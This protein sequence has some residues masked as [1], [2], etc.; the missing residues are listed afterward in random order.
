MSLVNC[1]E[2]GNQVSTK[3]EKCPHC[4]APAPVEK[5]TKIGCIGTVIIVIVALII[6][7][8]ISDFVNKAIEKREKRKAQEIEVQLERK[9]K[10]K[11]LQIALQKQKEKNKFIS[12]IEIHYQNLLSH[13]NTGEYDDL[14]K[15]LDKFRE[16]GRIGYKDVK[17]IS[18]EMR[19]KELVE[20]V[21]PIPS[22][23]V[24]ENLVI[25][26]ELLKLDPNNEQYKQKVA[27]YND[28]YDELAKK[29][30]LRKK[31]A[32]SDLELISWHWSKDYGYATA[33]G[34]VK[35]ISNRKL[36]NVEALV[37]WYNKS[38]E[39]ITSDSSLI[40]YNPIMPGQISP[41]QV[42]ESYNPAMQNATI[43]FKF[44]WGEP[45]RTFHD[46]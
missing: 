32:S 6:I 3:A 15:E 37:T 30:F 36:K 1:K 18:T 17:Q 10:E 11:E 41:F 24:L 16:F 7:G 35:N 46:K 31:K 19:I 22:S 12:D 29:E 5:Q 34:Q 45:I 14:R 40:E 2:C 20:K 27:F 39:M 13:Y 4:G 25:Y 42:M 38:G 21:K 33:K 26:E 8:G 43:E 23:K 28:R 9:R 44:M